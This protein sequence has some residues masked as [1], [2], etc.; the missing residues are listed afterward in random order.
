MTTNPLSSLSYT[1]KDFNTIYVEL[2][3]IVKELSSK[4]DPSISNESDPGVILLKADAIIADKNNYNIDKNVLEMYPE[5]V[6]QD[7]NAR[8]LY[9]Q[10]AYNMPWYKSATTSLT[11]KWVGRSLV[12][13]ESVTIPPYTMFTNEDGTVVYT[14]TQE[15]VLDYDKQVVSCNAI[16]G[17]YQTLAINGSQ[18]ITLI[19]LDSDNRVYLPES[20]IS[21]NGLFIKSVDTGVLWNRVDNLQVHPRGNFYYEFGIDT[22]N[23]VCYIEFPDDADK[24]LKSGVTIS[25]LVTQGSSGNV[26]ANNIDRFYSD[27]SV[28]VGSESVVLNSDTVTVY[29]PSATVDG[30]DPQTLTEAYRNY[31]RTAGT[32]NT[33][34][35]L[36]DYINAI[37]NSE[38]VSNA[39]V[40]DRTNDIQSSYTIKTEDTV[41]PFTVQQTETDNVVSYLKDT[42]SAVGESGWFE[43]NSSTR[44]M[45]EHIVTN[46]DV[47]ASRQFYRVDSTH[48]NMN[49]FNLKLY[50]LHT[51]GIISSNDTYNSTFELE[52]P[53]GNV[54]LEIKNYIYD[55]QCIQHDFVSIVSKLPCLFKNS[56]PL[57]IKI[58]PQHFLTTV[59][60][61]QVKRNIITS[62]WDVCNS[63]AV[64]F[65]DAPNYDV[66]YDTIQ[67]CDERIKAIILDEFTYTT[68]ATYWDADADEGAGAFKDI[69]ISNSKSKLIITCDEAQLPRYTHF[70]T[71]WN[72]SNLLNAYFIC[73]NKVMRY[74]NTSKQFIEYSTLRKDIQ[75]EIIAKSVLG[76]RTP[77]FKDD[78]RFE[79]E[80]NHQYIDEVMADR[81]TTALV[82]SPFSNS[83]STLTCETFTVGGRDI[84]IAVPSTDNTMLTS[85]YTLKKNESGRFLAPAF[86]SDVNYSNYT[87]FE[88][89]LAQSTGVARNAVDWSESETNNTIYQVDSTD[90]NKTIYE[91]ISSGLVVFKNYPM[92]G[93]TYKQLVVAD[94]T[95]CLGARVLEG[96]VS[97]DVGINNG[98]EYLWVQSASGTNYRFKNKKTGGYLTV[99]AESECTLQD[100]G[101]D[102]SG[103]TLY[104]T[105][106]PERTVKY[107]VTTSTLETGYDPDVSDK[108]KCIAIDRINEWKLHKIELSDS[109]HYNSIVDNEDQWSLEATVEVCKC[110]SSASSVLEYT[111]A[112]ESKTVMYWLSSNI[113]VAAQPDNIK[114]TDLKTLK[115]MTDST[116]SSGSVGFVNIKDNTDKSV[117]IYG[118]YQGTTKWLPIEYEKDKVSLDMGASFDTNTEY[119]GT[120]AIIHDAWKD[121]KIILY[122][123][124]TLYSIPANC[125]YQLKKGD[126]I[127]FFWRTDD[128][129]E[130]APYQYRKYEGVDSHN[131]N[132]TEQ[133]PIIRPSFVL[134]GT[135]YDK[136]QIKPDSLNDTGTIAYGDTAYKKI[137]GMYG[138]NDLSGSKSIETRHMKQSVFDN[139]KNNYY[140]ITNNVTDSNEYRMTFMSQQTRDKV[141]PTVSN[142]NTTGVYRYTLQTDEYFVRTNKTY[143]EYEIYYPGTLI[144]IDIQYTDDT[145]KSDHCDNS[146]AEIVPF[147]EYTLTAHCVPYENIIEEGIKAFSD[148][149]K[150]IP[151]HITMYAREQQVHNVVEDNVLMIKRLSASNNDVL[152]FKSWEDTLV[153]SDFEVSYM[154]LNGET[155]TLP[156][157]D[158]QSDEYAWTGRACLNL[159]SSADDPQVIVPIDNH[160]KSVQLITIPQDAESKTYPVFSFNGNGQLNTSKS[161]DEVYIQSD[162]FVNRVGGNNIDISYINLYADR[163]SVNMYLY[164][165]N[166]VFS[167]EPFHIR[168]DDGKILCNLGELKG[169][170]TASVPLRLKSDSSYM[171]A[172][173]LLSSNS[174]LTLTGEGADITALKSTV[175]GSSG[176]IYYILKTHGSAD[177]CEV[178]LHFTVDA[179]H[180]YTTN[181]MLIF[182]SLFRFTE[183]TLFEDRYDIDF[184]SVLECVKRLDIDNIYKYN[185]RIDVN[186]ELF[187]EDPLDSVSFFNTNHV[188]NQHTIAK[189]ELQMAQGN[190]SYITVIN[191]R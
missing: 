62:L 74:D 149:C 167:T 166:N 20:T 114:Y 157:I 88:L 59:Q 8:N 30:S 37:Y 45:V 40:T 153:T 152:T 81:V 32:F 130:D 168:A 82:V 13:G 105:Q 119:V 86:D 100:I 58:I 108:N 89:V 93:K 128:S 103:N 116:D 104:D 175:S 127:V 3:D 125:D 51:P 109:L 99:V 95:R 61:E 35:T 60:I 77:L 148:Y 126:S 71:D 162:V 185:N 29:N 98:D 124:E 69:P 90:Y 173:Q 182:D 169:S 65:G 15:V 23:S 131:A 48:S 188:M 14:T 174:T 136:A 158:I 28:T 163:A 141:V 72:K 134:K 102:D 155:I 5:T 107:T 36:R 53:D 112:P 24:L 122:K 54:E 64:D 2:L 191:N 129:N 179:S 138:D 79:Y 144:G 4:W 7:I 137:Y 31:R 1:N 9:K 73:G 186:D 139:G 6:T 10:L 106:N 11:F 57:G 96:N 161:Y 118:M 56:Y 44:E 164:S 97:A 170:K 78:S 63:R 143:T 176:R 83:D 165:V 16:E 26:S 142:P 180:T 21:E 87:K 154:T 66:I 84:D 38:L 75:T 47:T 70:N 19:H 160:N 18:I 22:R 46:D 156:T 41:N 110:D 183:N 132:A 187:I 178:T 117:S 147:N 12:A 133:S 172:L 135:S 123:E 150:S 184:S 145:Y 80:V 67:H 92:N 121:D 113:C 17:T 189:A 39:I 25:Y 34:V 85:E 33:L 52:A 190:D 101:S 27:L 42:V 49:A 181:D 50:L 146:G 115:I 68:F 140:L 171:L 76:G 177:D 120:A 55:Q 43:Y 91:Y 159:N 151:Y 94:G 111:D